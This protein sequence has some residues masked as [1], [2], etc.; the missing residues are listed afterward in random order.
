MF[1]RTTTTIFI[2]FIFIISIC[3]FTTTATSTL[4]QNNTNFSFSF[5]SFTL[6]NITLLGDS[7]LR[8]GLVGLTLST[9]VPASSSGTLF[10][11]HPITTTPSFSLSTN[12]TF[13]ITNTTTSATPS[14]TFSFFLNS[15]HTLLSLNFHPNQNHLT[16][17]L[18]V[19]SNSSITNS[20]LVDLSTDI[21]ITSWVDYHHTDKKKLQ[22]F[23]NYSSPAT[24]KP[25]NPVLS[26]DLDL[27]E[28]F[29]DSLY[30]GFSG[31]TQGSTELIQVMSWSLEFESNSHPL[32]NGSSSPSNVAVEGIPVSSNSTQGSKNRGKRFL[33]GL[34]VAIVGPAFFCL[35]LVVLGYVSFLKWRGLRK[36][37]GF[38]TVGC[39]P[40][41]FGYKE[42]K[43]ATKGFHASR[44]IGNGSFGTVYKALFESSGTIAAIKRSRQYD[45]KTEFLAELSIIASLRHKNLVQLLGWCVEKGEL[46]L[47]YEY[48]P[49]GS[50]DKVL[51]QECEGGSPNRVLSWVHRVNIAVGLASVLS[52]LHQECEQR[53]IHRDIK[54][55]NILLDGSMNPRLGDFGLAKLMDHDKSPVSTLTAG[56]MGYLAPEYLQCG[57]ATEKT[58]VFSYGVVVLEVACGRRPIERE[59]QKMVNLVD[60]VWGLH[61]QGRIIEAADRRLNGEFKE[62]EMKKL[63]LLGLSCANP[64]SAQRPSMRRVL[65]ILNNEGGVS[66][67]VP[68]EKPTLTFSSGLPLSLEDIVSDAEE[69]LNSGQVVCEIKID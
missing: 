47:V 40:K 19:S 52:Y 54:T 10:F 57:M 34:C 55:G 22:V 20:T 44:V 25:Q 50:L 45:G 3:L 68:K 60:W 32:I 33:F 65:Q 43:L 23:L 48:M 4:S 5:P 56:T 17:D 9:T 14:S 36:K 58:D 6:R 69:E 11:N 24:S 62:G 12:F 59:G 8:N 16:L 38:G 31:S 26:V 15:S 7:F 64:D 63:L 27:Y 28:Y 42:V 13:S 30:L 18:S 1:L 49:N 41:E 51:Y 53:V 29:K 21:P 2:I 35:V 46:L 66:L 39:C 61:S 67:V 37:K